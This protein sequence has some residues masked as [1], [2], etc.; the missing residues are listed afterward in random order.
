MSENAWLVMTLVVSVIALTFGACLAFYGY[1]WRQKSARLIEAIALAFWTAAVSV[2]LTR[3]AH[4]AALLSVAAFVA[5]LFIPKPYVRYLYGA[6][7]GA[8]F[9]VL[10]AILFVDIWAAPVIELPLLVRIIVMGVISAAG[11]GLGYRYS[12]PT[13][14]VS[15]ALAGAQ[16][17]ALGVLGLFAAA[18]HESATFVGL[19]LLAA[20]VP[21][22]GMIFAAL[23]PG[24]AIIHW[25]VVLLVFLLGSAQ[26][27]RRYGKKGSDLLSV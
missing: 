7:G 9:F 8:I 19:S 15:T 2:I 20:I 14:I 13:V 12:D 5:A 25:M 23:N 27:W 22:T 16:Y 17:T 26:Q 10:G 21:V 24:E 18:T 4:W 1:E 6:I 3:A 11:V